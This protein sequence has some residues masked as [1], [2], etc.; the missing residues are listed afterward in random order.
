MKK[1]SRSFLP[2]VLIFVVLNAFFLTGK[3][4]LQ[5]WGADQDVLITG[6]ALLFIV[7]FFSF[8]LAK[9]GLNNPNPHAFMRSVYSSIIV[10]MFVC[11]IAA[12]VYIAMLGKNLNKPALFTCMGLY[13]IYTF[14]EVSSLT[15]L[16]KQQ[17]G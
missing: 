9:R 4:M 7:T 13:L 14:L 5:R 11:M 16:L 17:K 10:K 12:L 1:S 6:N 3:A 15:R 2:I 8:L